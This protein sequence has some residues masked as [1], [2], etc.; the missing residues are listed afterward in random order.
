M[1]TS[2]EGCASGFANLEDLRTFV[3]EIPKSR[4]TTINNRPILKDVS[5]DGCKLLSS[6]ISNLSDLLWQQNP[7]SEIIPAASK[8]PQQRRMRYSLRDFQTESSRRH[9]NNELHILVCKYWPCS[10]GGNHDKKL[11]SCVNI[12]LCLQSDWTHPGLA[13][14]EFDIILQH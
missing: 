13:F 10:C 6:Q 5:I 12:M 11:G 2:T 7:Q 9:C 8:I 4:Q 1:L 3:L 14:G